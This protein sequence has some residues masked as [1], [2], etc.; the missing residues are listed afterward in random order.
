VRDE[1]GGGGGED[2]Q[3]P[4]ERLVGVYRR[5]LRLL[6]GHLVAALQG[7]RQHLIEGERAARLGAT[8]DEGRDG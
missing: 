3:R 4:G 8:Q 2:A 7:E 5:E 6:D 1:R